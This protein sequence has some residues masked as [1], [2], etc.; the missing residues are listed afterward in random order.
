M[1]RGLEHLSC[2]DRLRM[3]GL[4]SLE[5]GRLQGDLRAAFQCLKG[6]YKKAGEGLSARACS[7]RTRD[8][9]F[10][11]SGKQKNPTIKTTPFIPSCPG[12]TSL[13]HSRLL[14][15]PQGVQRG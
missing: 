14:Y 2:E 9:G 12:L 7:D 13:P 10:K 11:L 5:E 1:I 4:F 6:V 15:P 8:S 3:L